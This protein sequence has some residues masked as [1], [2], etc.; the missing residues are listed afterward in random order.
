MERLAM[1]GVPGVIT[2]ESYVSFFSLGAIV[3]PSDSKSFR[4]LS[5]SAA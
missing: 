5:S 3:R 2:F 1:K 4:S